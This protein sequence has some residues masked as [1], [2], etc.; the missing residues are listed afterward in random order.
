MRNSPSVRPR[1]WLPSEGNCEPAV[2][3][4]AAMLTG[5]LP[6]CGGGRRRCCGIG[7]RRSRLR[8]PRWISRGANITSG[9]DG[10]P[11]QRRRGNWAGQTGAVADA[12]L[13]ANVIWMIIL[14]VFCLHED[15]RDTAGDIAYVTSGESVLSL[16]AMRGQRTLAI[17]VSTKVIVLNGQS[18]GETS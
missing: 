16:G 18:K 9:G 2:I 13:V 12:R 11:W 1:P 7:I 4:W 6:G 14:S 3:R 5:P 17:A 8:R 10:K 15:E